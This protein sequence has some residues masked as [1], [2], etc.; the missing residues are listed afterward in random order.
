MP[1]RVQN[2]YFPADIAD[3][4]LLLI[5]NE[6]DECIKALF[7]TKYIETVKL[8]KWLYNSR[9]NQI[10]TSQPRV[11]TSASTRILLQHVLCKLEYPGK[12]FKHISME[13]PHDFR[14][15]KMRPKFHRDFSPL[16]VGIQL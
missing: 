5:N 14:I 15:S 3:T 2:E 10:S 11:N 12:I 4:T 9:T 16:D 13:H 6:S 7:D 1:A 8:Y